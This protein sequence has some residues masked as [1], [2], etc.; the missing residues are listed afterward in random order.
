VQGLNA[1]L[2]TLQ[3]AVLRVK[4][5]RLDAWNQARARHA[6]HYQ[7][8]L[9]A[10]GDLQLPPPAAWPE[11]VY[12]LFVVETDARDALQAYLS[13]QRIQ[14]G[15]HY[16]VPIHLQ[17]AYR[18]LGYATGDFPAAERAANRMLSLPMFPEMTDAQLERTVAAIRQFFASKRAQSDAAAAPAVLVKLG[19]S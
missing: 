10:V 8:L 18:E 11:H 17:E 3:A 9:R 16:P 5:A 1:R 19:A 15:I 14:T 6:A 4:L 13:E 7:A 12:H 2:D